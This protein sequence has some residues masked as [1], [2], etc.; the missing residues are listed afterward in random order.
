MTPV[1]T[2]EEEVVQT[3]PRVPVT[4][5]IVPG[6]SAVRRPQASELFGRSANGDKINW[7]TAFFMGAFHI[8]ALAA[9][10]LFSWQALVITVVLYF[11]AINMGVGM[12]YHRLLTH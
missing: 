5:Q 7:K 6:E 10:F 4:S 8:G 11:M 3:S 9:L 1:L 12:G 2:A